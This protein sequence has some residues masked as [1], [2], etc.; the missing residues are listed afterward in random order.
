MENRLEAMIALRR[1]GRS[2]REIAETLGIKHLQY[3]HRDL[4]QA[5]EL[6]RSSLWGITSAAELATWLSVRKELHVH[7]QNRQDKRCRNHQWVLVERKTSKCGTRECL[8][9]KTV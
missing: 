5:G 2:Y 1:S 4:R 9:V 3:V 6:D 8:K 7:L